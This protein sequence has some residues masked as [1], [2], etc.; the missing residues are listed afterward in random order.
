MV[1]A[2]GVVRRT[3]AL[4]VSETEADMRILH[5]LRSVG[6]LQVGTE[7]FDF[8]PLL[9]I[10]ASSVSRDIIREMSSTSSCT[11][12]PAYPSPS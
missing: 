6:S 4:S 10:I 3:N 7:T 8:K 2:L 12:L 11:H 9:L 5:R 1:K